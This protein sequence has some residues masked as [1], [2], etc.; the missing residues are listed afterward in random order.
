VN[1]G[2]G[3]IDTPPGS[4]LSPVKDELPLKVGELRHTFISVQTEITEL[5]TQSQELDSP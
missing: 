3:P 5:T 4:H 2:Y 1:L